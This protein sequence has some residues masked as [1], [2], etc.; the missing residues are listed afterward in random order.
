MLTD[1]FVIVNVIVVVPFKAMNEEAK[2]LLIEGGATT[3]VEALAVLPVPPFV[4]VTAPVILFLSPAVVPVAVRL[5]LQVP[6]GAIEAPL[7]AMVPGAV[8]VRV[9]PH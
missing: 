7:N 6:P 4:D 9:P 2:D 8:D 3:V 5:R 1:G